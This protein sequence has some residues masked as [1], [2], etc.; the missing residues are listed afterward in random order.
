M[1]LVS[2]ITTLNPV[3]VFF[4]L[5][6]HFVIGII[7]F[8]PSVFG[9]AW[10]ELSGMEMKADPKWLPVGFAAHIIYTI[11]LAVIINLA[12]ATTVLEGMVIGGIVS[13]GF[14]GTIMINEL[15]FMKIPFK[16][17]LIKFGDEFI[18]LITA[19]IILA[20]WK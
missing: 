4:A 10:V 9:K 16:L 18:S 12:Q 5:I 1:T 11:A 20:L 6:S 17:F 2:A 19:G 13:I 7:W 14:I 8:H 15:A 3:A